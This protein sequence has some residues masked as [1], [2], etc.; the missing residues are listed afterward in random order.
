MYEIIAAANKNIKNQPTS[1]LI[2][3][4]FPWFRATE[5]ATTITP[6][7]G[8]MII[9]LGVGRNRAVFTASTGGGKVMGTEGQLRFL[10]KIRPDVLI[11]MPTFV[12]HVLHQA[13]DEGV[14]CENLHRIVLG[15]EKVP[16]GMRL[17]LRNLALELGARE[18][19]VVTTYGFTEAMPWFLSHPM[20]PEVVLRGGAAHCVRPRLEPSTWLH[21]QRIPPAQG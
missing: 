16:D 9:G 20:P 14:R 11:G 17:K 18:L 10:R 12:Y 21:R 8:Y 5:I 7:A 13:A 4:S 2:F 15:G 6:K 19:D 3:F 1:I